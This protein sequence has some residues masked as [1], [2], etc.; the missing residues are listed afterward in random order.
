MLV[1][2]SVG[3]TWHPLTWQYLCFFFSCRVDF[4]IIEKRER[5]REMER[6]IVSFIIHHHLKRILNRERETFMKWPLG[7]RL[8]RCKST[9]M[10]RQTD[11]AFQLLFVLNGRKKCNFFKTRHCSLG[12]LIILIYKC[13]NRDVGT[14][15][16][17]WR[18]SKFRPFV[19]YPHKYS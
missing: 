10:N 19:N 7:F 11:R 17:W 3:V 6:E 1:L 18:A 12:K 15:R 5:E 9:P 14:N 2:M 16:K 4:K 8:K 13:P